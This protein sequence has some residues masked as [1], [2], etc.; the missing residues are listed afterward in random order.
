MRIGSQ[1][2]GSVNHLKSDSR[3]AEIVVSLSLASLFVSANHAA[4]GRG[5]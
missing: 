2:R 1:I 3:E 4:V 5:L